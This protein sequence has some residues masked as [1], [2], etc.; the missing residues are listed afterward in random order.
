MAVLRIA[1]AVLLLC[2]SAAAVPTDA[3]L[4]PTVESAEPAAPPEGAM[5]AT[6]GDMPKPDFA[7][8]PDEMRPA[9]GASALPPDYDERHAPLGMTAPPQQASWPW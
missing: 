7:H 5:S 6:Q 1:A 4:S 9:D 2:S 8:I 3:V